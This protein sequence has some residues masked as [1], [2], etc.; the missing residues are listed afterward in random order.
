[1]FYTI[2]S[3]HVQLHTDDY[4]RFIARSLNDNL[5]NIQVLTIALNPDCMGGEGMKEKWD[6]SLRILK[7]MSEEMECLK[8]FPFP[9]DKI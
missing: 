9:K 6:N 2:H 5:K 3:P 7:I 1:M 8:S 4:I